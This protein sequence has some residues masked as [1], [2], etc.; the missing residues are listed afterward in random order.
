MKTAEKF[1]SHFSGPIIFATVPDRESG[2]FRHYFEDYPS[3]LPKLK[4][5]NA[6]HRGIF[7][8]VNEL[9]RSK[10]PK[11][12]RTKKM[13][14]RARAIWV[15]D[16][17]KRDEPRDDWPLEPNIIVQSSPGKYHYYWLTDTDDQEAWE[18]Q[19]DIMTDYFGCDPQ[20]RDLTR[21]L[22]IPGFNH[23]KKDPVKVKVRYLREKPYEFSALQIAFKPTGEPI[24]KRAKRKTA[25]EGRIDSPEQMKKLVDDGHKHGPAMRLA[26]K[27]ANQGCDLDT[28][29]LALSPIPEYSDGDHE[30]CARTALEKVKLE[31]EEDEEAIDLSDLK[32]PAI[33][34]THDEF[35]W[36]PGLFGEMCEQAYEMA[37]YPYRGVSIATCLAMTAPL[38]GRNHNVSGT[39]LNIYISLLMDTGMGKDMIRK[40]IQRTYM[41]VDPL[42]G[43][44]FV[45]P[46]R[47]T[48]VPALWRSV[49][50]NPNLVSVIT[51]AGFMNGSDVGDKS[52]LKATILSMYGT[53]GAEEM[54]SANE[55]SSKDNSLP[56][57]HSPNFSLIQESTP[58]S[59]IDAMLKSE[60]DVNG[61]LPR[62]WILRLNVDK[63]PRNRR[64]RK[65]F[66]A[67]VRTRLSKL[68]KSALNYCENSHLSSDKVKHVDIPDWLDEDSDR[69]VK[70]ENEA[71][72]SG[73]NL[74][75][76][77]YTRA[78]LKAVK[79]AAI[80]D[81]FN[82]ETE[83]QKET[84]QWTLTNVIERE[85]GTIQTTVRENDATDVNNRWLVLAQSI[86]RVLSNPKAYKLNPA[87]AKRSVFTT[88][89]M[90]SA[91]KNNHVLKELDTKAS[92]VS[93]NG[94]QKL[95]DEMVQAG[96]L[97]RLDNTGIRKMK[98]C[99]RA[100]AQV[101]YQITEEFKLWYQQ[102][103]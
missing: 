33:T 101:A 17:E 77:I 26:M 73:D 62:M 49:T 80:I 60:G 63:P 99:E 22:R 47:F 85:V 11:R 42:N 86:Q 74:R 96:L 95:F 25:A 8:V 87:F 29:L 97:K 92:R 75:K 68:L 7:F 102:Q 54:Q 10:D 1:L 30:H 19:M 53:S 59:F 89:V 90:I 88:S 40:I 41:Q 82:G 38:I 67:P 44:K 76:V 72:A 36:P 84:Y 69:F 57:I 15:E 64:P 6:A 2:S 94:L 65:R 52:G 51:E 58:K 43:M 45:G 28:I 16:D 56:V 46:A 55:Y 39:G 66:E 27:L 103:E 81:V 34:N 91:T 23:C 14:V 37:H 100:R 71:R 9:D 13:F 4:R 31:S 48:G 5:D 83:I 70:L 35:T 79:I 61:E 93:S 12:K 32:G 3:V 98:G 78:W 50:D 20:A 21:V 18:E 24:R